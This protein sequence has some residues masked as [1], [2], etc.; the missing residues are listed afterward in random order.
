MYTECPTTLDRLSNDA[1]A[2][3]YSQNFSGYFRKRPLPSHSYGPHPLRQPLKQYYKFVFVVICLWCKLTALHN[4]YS[5]L[6]DFLQNLLDSLPNH[7]HGGCCDCWEVDCLL[8]ESLVVECLAVECLAVECLA[9]AVAAKGSS[10]L[11]L[12]IAVVTGVYLWL[13]LL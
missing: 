7:L 6:F 1:E 5:L 3:K 4:C 11:L 2:V 10:C 13:H 8:A 9:V 12:P